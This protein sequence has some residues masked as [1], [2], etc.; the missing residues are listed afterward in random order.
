[1][2]PACVSAEHSRRK[3]CDSRMGLRTSGSITSRTHHQAAG[4]ARSLKSRICL[5]PTGR[6]QTR[7]AR[8]LC[9]PRMRAMLPANSNTIVSPSAAPQ[10]QRTSTLVL[11]TARG[12]SLAQPFTRLGDIESAMFSVG[13]RH[14]GEHSTLSLNGP[15]STMDRAPSTRWLCIEDDCFG[16]TC[17]SEVHFGIGGRRPR[18][19]TTRPPRDYTKH[20][21]DEPESDL[22]GGLERTSADQLEPHPRR[23]NDVP[24]S[25]VERN[26]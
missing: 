5:K 7:A 15:M 25:P 6:A 11:A 14:V 9:E 21:L 22:R 26:Q 19:P 23:G 2:H 13:P 12:S 4:S 10:R 17:C 24:K 18:E 20:T 8:N 3:S 1:L 16:P